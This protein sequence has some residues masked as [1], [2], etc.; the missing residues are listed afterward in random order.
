[1]RKFFLAILAT[2]PATAFASDLETLVKHQRNGSA[3]WQI[4][5]YQNGENI[6]RVNNIRIRDGAMV[7]G[8]GHHIAVF[9][10]SDMTCLFHQMAGKHQG[11]PSRRSLEPRKGGLESPRIKR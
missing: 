11:L 4:N 8:Q 6:F 10:G 5:C 2:L 7:D 1:M 3:L 9:R